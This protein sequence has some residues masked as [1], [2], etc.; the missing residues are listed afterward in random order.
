MLVLVPAG[1]VSAGQIQLGG[2][3][4]LTSAYITSG[5]SGSSCVAGSLGTLSPATEQNYDTVLFSGASNGGVAPT[6]YSTYNQTAPA[7]G[8][9]TD[10]TNNVT[11]SMVNDGTTGGQSNNYWSLPD[12]SGHTQNVMTIPVG[13]FGVTD[14]W[15]MIN[16]ALARSFPRQD[17]SVVFN[18]GTSSNSGTT[19]SVLIRTVNSNDSST[20]AGQV[21]NAVDCVNP[22]QTCGGVTSPASGPLSPSGTPD[23]RLNGVLQ[24]TPTVTVATNNLYSFDYASATGAYAGST[25]SVNLDD[26]GFFFN[27]ISL[28]A[29]GA[30]DTNLNTYLVS[31]QIKEVG[32]AALAGEAVGLSAITLDTASGSSTPEPSAWLLFGVGLGAIGLTRYRR[33]A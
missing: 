19:E 18:F 21:R 13:V 14:A 29:L 30:G 32:T 31:I 28:A 23:E 15:T 12:A 33:K 3:S 16:D 10:T 8:T 9:I 22:A 25:G 24:A 11:F 20:D 4:G 17:L 7:A 6:P 26:Q 1:I 2:T 27:D 5:C